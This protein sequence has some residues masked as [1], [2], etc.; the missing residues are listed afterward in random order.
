MEDNLIKSENSQ[1]RI[2]EIE[3]FIFS[4]K[5]T[6]FESLKDLNENFVKKMTKF[7]LNNSPEEMAKYN[8]GQMKNEMY[9]ISNITPKYLIVKCGA[10]SG[11]K[12][13]YKVR[14][15]YETNQDGQVV[16]ICLKNEGKKYLIQNNF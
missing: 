12:C 6:K 11:Q 8:R 1:F 13:N 7:H 3:N 10:K 2:E 9:G 5:N 4:L 16:N 15:V 14:F